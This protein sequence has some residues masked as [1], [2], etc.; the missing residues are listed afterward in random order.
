MLKS[1]VL[2][3]A[4][5]CFVALP[6]VAAG[7]PASSSAAITCSVRPLYPTPP[8]SHAPNHHTPDTDLHKNAYKGEINAVLDLLEAGEI[9]VNAQGAQNRTALHRAVGGKQ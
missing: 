2:Y 6:C 1:V 9:D 7:S 4:L 8:L 3:A 5:Y